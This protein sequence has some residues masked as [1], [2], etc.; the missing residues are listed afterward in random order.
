MK[1]IVFNLSIGNDA[2]EGCT[3]SFPILD[4]IA[5]CFSMAKNTNISAESYPVTK[6]FIINKGSVFINDHL[7]KQDEIFVVKKQNLIGLSTDEGCVYTEISGREDLIMNEVLNK[8]EVLTLKDLLPY[9]DG[10]IVNMDLMSN[11]KMKLALMAFGA[12]TGLDEHAAPGEALIFALDGEA[13]ISYEGK[14]YLIHAGE[15]FRFN[16]GGLHAVKADKEF[17]MALL[18]NLGE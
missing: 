16:K 2:P 1:N 13:T 17:K 6:M 10:K 7:I 4:K 3:V 18:L 8:N 5:T 15:N 14:D 9:Q 11:E 12:G